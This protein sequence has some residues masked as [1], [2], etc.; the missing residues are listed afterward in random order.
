MVTKN[1]GDFQDKI[2]F[3][4]ALATRPDFT[5]TTKTAAFLRKAAVFVDNH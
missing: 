1:G 3:E 5:I 2:G 4:M